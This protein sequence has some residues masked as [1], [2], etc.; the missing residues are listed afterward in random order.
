MDM[1][2]RITKF[3]LPILR[4][5][6][7][8]MSW[9]DKTVFLTGA[10][11]GIGE[12]LALEM[13]K[14]GA[15][16]GLL[17]R[18]REMLQDLAERCEAAGGKARVFAADVTDAEA[19]KKA[20]ADFCAE[21]GH[22]DILIANAGVGG[23]AHAS[24]MDVAAVTNIININLIGTINSVAAVLPQMIERDSGQL[25]AISSLAG[26]RGLPK[27]AAYCASKAGVSNFFE[28]LRL[29]LKGTGIDVTIVHPGFI[30]T[31]LT[32]GRL[33]KM[34]FLMELEDGVNR[35]LK[36]IEKKKASA[37]FPFPLS[38]LVRAANFFPRRL[39]DFIAGGANYRT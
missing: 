10:S 35:I 28:S 36:I 15:V 13:A 38:T 19:I 1:I 31:P 12:G 18:R 26:Y 29:D 6:F 27:S 14:R 32:M 5:L 30:K 24:E 3:I 4:I 7:I 21:F 2:N 16:L 33:S 23:S 39:Y 25:V 8:F 22:I 20:A 11:S 37:A 34:P 9:K 17:A